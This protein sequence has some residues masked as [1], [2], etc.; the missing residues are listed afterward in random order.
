MRV[1][2]CGLGVMGKNHLRV[3]KKLGFEIVSTYEPQRGDV[4]NDFL[5]TL[6]DTEA[7]IIACPTVHHTKTI[8]D[9]KRVNEKIKILCEKPISLSSSDPLLDEVLEYDNSILVGQVERFNPVCVEI[10]DRTIPEEV[11]QV[12]TRRVNNVPA[13][14]KID[15]RKDIGIHDLD[16]S[17]A[18]LRGFPSQVEIMSNEDFS[19]ENLFC[20]VGRSMVVNEVSWNYPFKD[21]TFEVLTSQGL[22]SGHFYNQELYFFDWRGH[23]EEIPVEKREPLELE[24]I[25]F[26]KIVEEKSDP[27]IRVSDNIKILELMGY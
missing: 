8:I 27:E 16:F 14:E 1:S 11:I 5:A 9:A 18:L 12:K 25:H 4:Y 6:T 24:L 7:L 3:C 15:C 19:H 23:K 21:R 26:K 17:C 20:K 2:I 10:F 22:Y 13:R